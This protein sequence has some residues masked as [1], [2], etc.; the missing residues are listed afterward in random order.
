MVKCNSKGKNKEKEGSA[1]YLRRGQERQVQLK[2]SFQF[3]S[4]SNECGP[5]MFDF[6]LQYPAGSQKLSRTIL[7]PIDE[8]RGNLESAS[9]WLLHWSYRHYRP[10]TLIPQLPTR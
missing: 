2:T 4:R 6:V 3:V 9:Y 7:A 10:A 1:A 5:D 8:G